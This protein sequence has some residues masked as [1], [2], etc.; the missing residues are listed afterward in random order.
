MAKK[1]P[2]DIIL[3]IQEAEVFDAPVAQGLS[4]EQIQKRCEQ[5]LTNAYKH[6]LQKSVFAIVL[7]SVF[8]PINILFLIV[9]VLGI[10]WSL[11]W[12][13]YLPFAFLIAQT[14]LLIRSDLSSNRQRKPYITISG[15]VIVVRDGEKKE[16]LSQ[17][18][19]LGDIVYLG[20]GSIVPAD[21]VLV[22]GK[23]MA[24]EG[25]LF[26]SRAPIWKSV[27]EKIYCDS[28]IIEGSCYARIGC[29]GAASLSKSIESKAQTVSV[30]KKD[31]SSIIRQ[32]GFLC[33]IV[34]ALLLSCGFASYAATSGSA[35]GFFY[36]I[37]PDNVRGQA[38]MEGI[39][40]PIICMLPTGMLFFTALSLYLRNGDLEKHGI[41]VLDS[42][43]LASCA[44]I[45]VIC[46]DK[47]GTL[48]D[49]T[50]AVTDY[51]V[52]DGFRRTEV[53]YAIATILKYTKDNDLLADAL[54]ARFGEAT[55]E[56]AD[57]TGS[58]AETGKYA[59]VT[60]ALENT[61]A[62]GEIESLPIHAD[63]KIAQIVANNKA[64]GIRTLALVSSE[65]PAKEHNLPKNMTISALIFVAENIREGAKE[66]IEALQSQDLKIVVISGDDPLVV[67]SLAEQL[68]IQ[69]ADRFVSLEGKTNEEILS[70]A[71]QYRVFGNAS[72]EQ[73]ALIVSE[74][75]KHGHHVAMVGNG[76]NDILA[77]GQAD[78]SCT[79][80]SAYRNAKAFASFVSE[81]SGLSSLD[82]L[83]LRGNRSVFAAYRICTLYLAKTLFV[84]LGAIASL[85]MAF[86]VKTPYNAAFLYP[87]SWGNLIALNFFILTI[88]SFVFA[89][90]PKTRAADPK[91]LKSVFKSALPMG[92][93][94][95]LVSMIPFIIYA[96]KPELLASGDAD[97][98]AAAVS[99]A[100]VSVTSLGFLLLGKLLFPL[101]KIEIPV[102]ALALV[103]PTLAFIVDLSMGGRLFG[104]P[105]SE[106]PA[107]YFLV[108]GLLLGSAV[109][110]YAVILLIQFIVA[111]KAKEK[112]S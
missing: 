66:N 11:A 100:S 108:F 67:S 48:T 37:S 69:N 101:Q 13:Y 32:S 40:S 44:G 30:P 97:S 112:Q 57:N 26:G 68:G 46:F 8:A 89:I 98:Y 74:L 24:D 41:H 21:S 99:I 106:P 52:M 23:C 72:P 70:L 65:K 25:N 54:R 17:N 15:N 16:V 18:L 50:L 7:K 19:V 28:Q 33:A 45:D 58:F 73:K 5:G 14:V 77:F 34:A 39:L 9:L 59:F 109:L 110:V 94:M 29:V 90:E 2:E 55:V 71:S 87:L 83:F 49:G 93:L 47:T 60:T 22:E 81:N 12:Y 6:P 96:A 10:I 95:A 36:S 88:P 63:E 76:V 3:K 78:V 82:T 64:K 111:R 75:R 61:Y 62:I 51:E 43:A 86:A 85:F 31:L 104:F 103:A 27:G 79:Y 92:V 35:E 4:V 105:S 91:L 56:D 53:D 20:K 84:A 1:K 42:E 38:F 80:A 107:T 102:L